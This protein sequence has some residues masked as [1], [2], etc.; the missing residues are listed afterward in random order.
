MMRTLADWEFILRKCG[1]A[2]EQVNT[3]GPVF[4]SG[5]ADSTF[6]SE[7]DMTVWLGQVLHESGMLTHLEENLNYSA[8]RLMTVWPKRFPTSEI[9]SLYAHNPQALAD[10]VYGGRMGNTATGSGYKYRGRGLL[11]VTGRDNYLGLSNATG[12]DFLTQPELLAEPKYALLSAITW[13]KN[14]V[15]EDILND[16]EAVTRKVNGGLV[17]LADRTRLTDLA[18]GAVA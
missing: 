18:E 8:Q 15:H 2:E 10:K 17:G 1:V 12:L 5:V 4:T 7:A 14:N 6:R 13:W 16:S 9:A 3:W 11:Q